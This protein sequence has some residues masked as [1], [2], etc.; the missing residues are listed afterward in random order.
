MCVEGFWIPM[1]MKMKALRFTATS[2][3]TKPATQ[4]YIPEDLNPQ[5]QG[6]M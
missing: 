2:G 5:R 1:R 3:N 4:R 6:S